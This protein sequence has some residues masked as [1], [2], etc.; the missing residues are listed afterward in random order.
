MIG[1][2]PD[3]LRTVYQKYAKILVQRFKERD[4]NV[5]CNILDAFIA[6][7][8]AAILSESS[9]GIEHQVQMQPS[10]VRAA[11]SMDELRTLVPMIIDELV[12]LLKTS[13]SSRVKASVMHTL[14]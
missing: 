13:K 10:L 5:K 9:Q 12:K 11:S 8:R 2:R 4:E 6:L 14:A 3:K 1:S 7:L